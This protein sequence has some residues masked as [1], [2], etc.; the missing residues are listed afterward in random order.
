M[1]AAARPA[2]HIHVPAWLRVTP[3][4]NRWSVAAAILVAI[5]LQVVLPDRLMP[6]SRW[7]FPGLELALLVALIVANPS[8]LNK[9]STALRVASLVLSGLMSVTNAWSATILVLGLVHG[10]EGKDAASLLSAGAAIWLTNI[11]AFG[12]WYW[13]FDRGGPAARA[14]ARRTQPDFQF[15]QMQNPELT[16][17]DWEPEFVDY[18]YLSFTNATAFSP[19]D[20]MPLSRWAKLT[21]L[22]QSLVSLVTIALVIARAVNILK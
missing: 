18:L 2:H 15:V 6:Q 4:E 10:Q 14:H 21:M 11:I 8:R 20:V 19:T 5:G 9:E 16:H 22:F 12:L 3:G 13:Q 1:S 17:P 7:L